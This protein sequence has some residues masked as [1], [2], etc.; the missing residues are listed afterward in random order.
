MQKNNKFIQPLE[1]RDFYISKL[2]RYIISIEVYFDALDETEECDIISQAI[3]SF[4]EG[5]LDGDAAIVNS[6]LIREVELDFNTDL[7]FNRE[8]WEIEE[9]NK[10]GLNANGFPLRPFEKTRPKGELKIWRFIEAET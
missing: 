8:D 5:Q 10:Q 3:S 1:G 6:E 4:R 9:L 2:C 7:P